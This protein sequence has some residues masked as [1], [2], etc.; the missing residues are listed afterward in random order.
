MARLEGL[1]FKKERI[2]VLTGGRA[3]KI[4]A[5]SV[6]FSFLVFSLFLYLEGANP[7]EAYLNIF[8]FAL[9]PELGLPATLHRGL[10]MLFSALAFIVVYR[11]GIWNVGMEGQFYLG[12]IGAFAVA[13]AF[14]NL[15]S[16][17]LIPMMLASAALFGAGY[18]AITGFLKGKLDVNEVVVALML[19]N[20]AF[21]LVY[22]LTVGGPWAGS[23]ASSSRPLPEPARAP[24]IW[25]TPFTSLL[26]AALAVILYIFLK[27]T[28]LGYQIKVYGGNPNVARHVGI[29]SLKVSVLVMALGGAISGLAGYHMWAG[30]AAFYL[31]PRPEA[32]KAV[33]DMTYWGIIIGLICL[34]NP[35]ASIPTSIFIGA[36][37]VGST[38]LVRRFRLPFGLDILFLGIITISF[39]AFQFFY[40][41]RIK[42]RRG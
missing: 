42:M 38:V 14:P 17:V 1:S 25:E 5:L 6:A 8:S 27:Y 29:S 7:V 36:I 26:A 35:L 30:D 13:F 20:I 40:N 18:G 37:T 9:A 39:V 24:R 15:P 2:I 32:Y 4:S 12:T 19:N 22:L 3:V 28:P 34:L 21:W 33:G 10:F 41:Y 11:A 23:I 16:P 31:I